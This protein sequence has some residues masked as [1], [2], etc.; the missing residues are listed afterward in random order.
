METGELYIDFFD[1]FGGFNLYDQLLEFRESKMRV[2][3]I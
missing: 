2:K 3:T 1:L